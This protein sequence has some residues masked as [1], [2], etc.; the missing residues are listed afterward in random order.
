MLNKFTTLGAIALLGAP[1]LAG[2]NLLTNG[3]FETPGP[4]I[5]PFAGWTQQFFG[6]VFQ[7]DSGEVAPQDGNFTCKTFGTFPGPG[8]QGDS[9][10]IQRIP[11]TAGLNYVAQVYVQNSSIDPLGADNLALWLVQW[12]DAGGGSLGE[13]NVQ[14]A[15]PQTPLD[16]WNL[17]TATG[18]AP[19]GAAFA[20]VFLLFLQF[21]NQ[22][23]SIFWDNASFVQGDPPA[24]P[25]NPSDIAEPF[26]LLDLADINAFVTGFLQGCD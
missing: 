9:G 8:V 23:G 14:A 18:V 19:A 3:S 15:N 26:G 5:I 16:Q 2:T 13:L 10:L 1:A 12:K 17:V 24:E 4:G 6:N 25:C 11:V 20:D 22:G 21:N 7:A